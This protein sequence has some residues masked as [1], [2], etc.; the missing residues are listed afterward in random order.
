MKI[1][2]VDMSSKTGWSAFHDGK[3]TNYGLITT[4][5]FT[6]SLED[7]RY[8]EMAE[9][10]AESIGALILEHNPD[11]IIIEQTNMGRARGS[12]KLL[13]FCHCLF[14]Q[15]IQWIGVQ[16]KIVYVDT[17][18]WRSALGIK[19]SPEQRIHNKLVKKKTVRGKITPKHLAVDFVNEKF[20]L[21]FKLK[22]NDICDSICLG[23]MGSHLN[24]TNKITGFTCNELDAAFA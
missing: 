21:G 16:D 11:Y 9:Y 14:L 6:N 19:L 5:A 22:D 12:Q 13:E 2:G 3:L 24:L 17:S 8:Y 23:L 18:Q 4:P 7:L 20:N 15:M 10:Q 1:L